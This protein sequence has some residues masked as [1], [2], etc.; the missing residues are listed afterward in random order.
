MILR[1]EILFVAAIISALISP[2]VMSASI[3]SGKSSQLC[4][5][6]VGNGGPT[7]AD[8]YQSFRMTFNVVVVDGLDRA[9]I[10]PLNRGGVWTI[11][12]AGAYVPIEGEFPNS[13]QDEYAPNTSTGEVIGVSEKLGVFR[14]RKG[15]AQFERLYAADGEPFVRPLSAAY[16]ARLGGTVISDKSGLY[17]LGS[18][19]QLKQL[20]WDTSVGGTSPGRIFDLPELKLLLF[21]A[22]GYIYARGDDGGLTIFD[23]GF[24]GL[25]AARVKSDG[26][27]FLGRTKQNV[28]VPWPPKD[29]TRPPTQQGVNTDENFEGIEVYVNTLAKV[30][31][32]KMQVPLP[33]QVYTPPTEFPG[34]VMVANA[35]SDGLYT[36][37]KENRWDLVDRSDEVAGNV[38]GL[39]RLPIEN[40]ALLMNGKDRLYLLVEKSDSRATNCLK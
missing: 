35:G 19:G 33:L 38:M 10:F 7:E 40:R 39:F 15:E 30:H 18:S 8:I 16:V 20:F 34:G 3:L 12:A 11:N 36:L 27:I 1:R 17:L 2:Q 26:S 13:F 5:V 22:E 31:D 9:I 21:T 4:L 14:L 23:K 29:P 25:R 32:R 28:I 37:S 24:D 6:P